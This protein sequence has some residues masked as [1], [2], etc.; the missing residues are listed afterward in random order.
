MLTALFYKINKQRLLSRENCLTSLLNKPKDH[1]KKASFA[2]L[3]E[4]QLNN[5]TPR[6]RVTGLMN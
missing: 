4:G 3:I 2:A 5:P 1:A 6:Q